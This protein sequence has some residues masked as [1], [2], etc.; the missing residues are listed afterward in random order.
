VR[1][2][3]TGQVQVYE[4]NDDSPCGSW[5]TTSFPYAPPPTPAPPTETPV[6][7]QPTRTRTPTR[8]PTQ[9]ATAP[10]PTGT[11]TQT[12]T[13]PMPTITPTPG[14]TQLTLQASSWQWDWCLVSAPCHSGTC[15]FEIGSP[16]PGMPGRNG[17][18]LHM[19]CTYQLTVLNGDSP[20]G[21]QTQPHE[22]NSP[23][24]NNIGF[25]A[26]DI[27]PPGYTDPTTYTLAIPSGAPYDIN[28]SCFNSSCANG[29]PPENTHERMLGVIHIAP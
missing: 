28:F 6:P 15:P 24:N 18:T 26:N 13:A 25:P 17:I 4:K 10:A 23:S 20:F 27:L 21:D 16:V 3:G 9:A 2:V 7:G 22:T 29:G 11:P 12:A 5:D 14:I 1:D 19:G 8:P